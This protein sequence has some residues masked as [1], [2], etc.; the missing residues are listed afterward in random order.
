MANILNRRQ[1]AWMAL[2]CEG[3]FVPT[4][5]DGVDSELNVLFRTGL[6]RREAGGGCRLTEAGRR[7]ARQVLA[8]EP[9]PMA[10]EHAPSEARA[11]FE[12]SRRA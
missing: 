4:A 10:D 9:T 2:A 6:L 3:A 11:A 5:S 8:L 12:G 1:V 7:Y